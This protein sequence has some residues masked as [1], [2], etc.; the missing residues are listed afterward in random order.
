[1]LRFPVNQ[2]DYVFV[3]R[4]HFTAQCHGEDASVHEVHLF[5]TSVAVPSHDEVV[6]D[7]DP[8]EFSRGDD[9]FRGGDIVVARCEI[10]RGVVVA[11]DDAMG[12]VEKGRCEELSCR[13]HARVDRADAD[14]LDPDDRV[15][16]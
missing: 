14:R 16:C 15:P 1:M 8:Q 3:G 7:V 10:P 11:E 5:E 4:C 12:V 6:A 13:H 2:P 9:S